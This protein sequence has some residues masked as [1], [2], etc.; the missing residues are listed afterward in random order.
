MDAIIKRMRAGAGRPFIDIVAEAAT[1]RLRP[2]FLT[3]ITTVI[4]MV[5]LVLP[6]AA[7]ARLVGADL[8]HPH[9][10]D[11]LEKWTAASVAGLSLALFFLL[12]LHLA[13]LQPAWITTMILGLGSVMFTTVGQA[14]WPLVR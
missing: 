11:R 1:T 2:I 7:A 12:A 13:P 9:V 6:V 10:H 4:G 5:P 14:L 8:D 3:T